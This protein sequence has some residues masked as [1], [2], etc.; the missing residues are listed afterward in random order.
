MRMGPLAAGA[1]DSAVL[2]A[3]RGS[4]GEASANV[5]R[6]FG[7]AAGGG[8]RSRRACSTE[9]RRS[10]K[11]QPT[12]AHRP[13]KAVALRAVAVLPPDILPAANAQG[14]PGSRCQ[15]LQKPE[16]VR[17]K[18][19]AAFFAHFSM[20][21]SKPRRC[22]LSTWCAL[23]ATLLLCV[24]SF[25]A[26]R[27][28]LLAFPTLP[29]FPSLATSQPAQP[30]DPC[31]WPPDF[32]PLPLQEFLGVQ[33]LPFE[34]PLL[35]PSAGALRVYATKRPGASYAPHAEFWLTLA[36]GS[37]E[38]TTFRVLK[39]ALAAGAAAGRGTHLDIGAW[40]GPT[41]LFAAALAAGRVLALEPDPR[42][43]N[44]LLANLA[45][46]PALAR[47]T[48]AFRHCLSSAS[49][50]ATMTGPAP[51]GSSMS[52]VHAL[53]RIPPQAAQEQNWGQDMVSWQVA[54]ST[55]RDFAARV[56]LSVSELALVKLDV[57]G[58]EALL[59]PPLVQ[60]L[61]EGAAAV[62]AAARRGAS[63]G[64]GGKPPLFLELHTSFWAQGAAPGAVA[65]ALAAYKHAFASHAER[66]GHRVSDNVLLPYQ[67]LQVLAATGALCPQAQEF[68]MVL[69]VDE[70][71]Q[72]VLELV[73]EG[74]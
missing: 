68:C 23:L 34:H 3:V 37:W 2:D 39:A 53:A 73:R 12:A 71:Q 74:G 38:P 36:D 60:W 35:P 15:R 61:Q 42:A 30:S 57:E 64:G 1:A 54:C 41:T 43:F 27:A 70:L 4:G 55:P 50:P 14:A 48:A 52:R 51:L 65:A 46:N 72:W 11:Y 26:G 49:G 69:C 20:K 7:A 21:P 28:S 63:G 40:V 25:S 18:Q 62:A 8:G 67:P 44:E 9:Y 22:G 33:T 10:A 31:A 58:A 59:L 19:D 24:L 5:T 47:R 66:P 56:G 13:K 16:R 32:R 6:P 29:A 17:G 45:L